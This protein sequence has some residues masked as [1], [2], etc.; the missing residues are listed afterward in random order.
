MPTK[1]LDELAKIAGARL[2]GD[3][4]IAVEDALPLQDACVACITLV[5]K[6]S[7]LEKVQDSAAVAIVCSQPLED[8][9]LPMLV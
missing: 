4:G 9:S 6:P 7:Q 3:G 5:D 8:C 1:R 2:I